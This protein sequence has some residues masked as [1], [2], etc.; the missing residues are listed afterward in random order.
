M[1]HIQ[2]SVS[3]FTDFEDAISELRTFGIELG[4]FNFKTYFFHVFQGFRLG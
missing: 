1:T 2:K 3:D 4:T